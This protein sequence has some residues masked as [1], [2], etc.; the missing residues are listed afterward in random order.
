M[1]FLSLLI[2]IAK[3][4]SGNTIPI[5]TLSGMRESGCFLNFGQYL[6]KDFEIFD[7]LISSNVIFF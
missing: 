5:N 3:L 4:P 6:T 7:D 1:L 2:F